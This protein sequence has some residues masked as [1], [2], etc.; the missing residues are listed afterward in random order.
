MKLKR[1]PKISLLAMSIWYSHFGLTDELNLDFIQ[2]INVV[3]SILKSDTNYPEGQYVVDVVVNKERTGRLGLNISKEDEQNN[4]LCFSPEWLEKAGVMLN[5]DAYQDV[6]DEGKGCYVLAKKPHTLIYFDYGAQALNFNIPQAYLLSKTDPTRWDYGVNGGRLKYYGNFNKT[7]HDDMNAFGNLDAA[8]N[9]GRWVLSS[10]MNVSHDKDKTEFTSSDLT[11]STAISQVQGDLLLGKSQTRTE[12]FSDFN[13]YGAALRSNSNMRPW[14][15]RGYVPDISGIASTPSRI[16]VKQNGYTVYSKMIPAGPYRLDDLRPMRNGDLVVTV[17][18]ESGYKTEQV[19]PVTTLPTLLRPG[20]FQY[21]VAMGKKNNSNELDKAFHSDSGLFWLGSLDYGFSTTTLNSAFILND[22]YQAGGLGVTQ[23]LGGLGAVSL[24]ANVSK[25]SYDNGEEKSGQSFSV[26]YAKSFT[27]RTDLQLLTYRYQSKGYVE[28]AE[29]NPKDIW[30]YGNQ[31]SRYEA[32]LSHRF[33]GTY[34][35][36]SYWRQDYWMREGSDT[37]S[38]LSLSTSVFDSVSVFL[39]GSYSKYA[40]SDK[41]DYSVSLSLSVPFDL[42]GTR[43]YSSN[44]VGYTR[45]GGTTFNTSVSA[46]PTDRFNYSLSANAGSKGDRGA[47]ASA[48]YAFDAIQTN[49]GVS[50]SYNKHGSSQ[51]SFSGSVSGSVLGTTETGLLFTKE[52]SDTVGIV[53]IPGVEGVSVNGSMPTNSDGNTVVWLSEYSENSININMDNV[54][55]NME[56]ETTSY[57]VVPTE[58]A[59]VYRKF[60][61]ENVLRYIL[62][63]KDAQGNYLTGGD[64]KTEQG[65]NAGFISNNGVLLMNMLA[66]PKTVSVNTG[67]GKQCRFSMAGLK[68]NTNKVQEV[69]CE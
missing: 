40:W 54:L 68:A 58:K 67:D 50:R 5:T 18:D 60:G 37:G 24:S 23:M 12:L 26:K 31:K 59:M 53:S 35:S 21:N 10:N 36:G 13:F 1:L 52:S 20:E 46:M 45:T 38:T 25:A 57:N 2:G 32:R 39:N 49:M 65:L 43:H 63:V 11:L 33:D 41:A 6:F 7:V 8:I 30:R 69:R 44:S 64:A 16:T 66:E 19:Y 27:D 28:F 56:F 61:F 9:L 34:L 29:F 15:S 4:L 47:S 17:E 48:S 14:E 51:T 42:K 3:P 22:D 62:R 55:D